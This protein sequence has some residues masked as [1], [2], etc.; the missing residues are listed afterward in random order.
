MKPVID[1][2]QLAGNENKLKQLKPDT[3][4]ILTMANKEDLVV[5][6]P[7]DNVRMIDQLL[8]R[9]RQ[10]YIVQ[11]SGVKFERTELVASAEPSYDF[12]LKVDLIVRVHDPL[13]YVRDFAS[14]SIED[15]CYD[16]LR[17]TLEELAGRYYPS[18]RDLL[19]DRFRSISD[20][21]KKGAWTE[22]PIAFQS[23][24]ILARLGPKSLKA[25]DIWMKQRSVAQHGQ[26]YLAYSDD[27][28][29]LQNL[30]TVRATQNEEL[31]RQIAVIRA[32]VKDKIEQETLIKELINHSMNAIRRE[33]P[34]DAI[35][36]FKSDV[37]N[38][39]ASDRAP[40]QY[41][42]SNKKSGD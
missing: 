27:M 19:Q 22:G 18:D 37:T 1:S 12:E 41:L 36:R 14:L 21:V 38:R 16:D 29:T 9:Y 31:D 7:N 23:C 3:V 8:K 6:N 25:S 24:N 17:S 34:M 39:I 33:Q 42:P 10:Y 28:K 40:Q 30:N 4:A 35:G 11:T 13:W 20:Q 5:F 32:N 2:G 15:V 26:D